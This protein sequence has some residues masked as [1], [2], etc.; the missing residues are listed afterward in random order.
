MLMVHLILFL[1][2]ILFDEI[3]NQGAESKK[4]F[5]KKFGKKVPT[6]I[7][8]MISWFL[9]G[10][11]HGGQWN[12]IIGVG[13]FFGVVIILSEMLEKRGLWKKQRLKLR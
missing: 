7:G 6:W 2:N 9:I 10:F 4:A 12:Y 11:W 13:I 5:G 8:L 1:S 3:C